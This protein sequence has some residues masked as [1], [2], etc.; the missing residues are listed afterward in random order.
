MYIIYTYFLLT[1]SFCSLLLQL[2]CS[3]YLQRNSGSRLLPTSNGVVKDFGPVH[4]N[5]NTYN[6][7]QYQIIQQPTDKPSSQQNEKEEGV[8]PQ[9]HAIKLFSCKLLSF[10]I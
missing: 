2:L 7:Y 4:F 8:V 10:K 1:H 5:L 3:I 6:R 9:V